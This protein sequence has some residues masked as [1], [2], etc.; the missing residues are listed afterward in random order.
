MKSRVEV[1]SL[2]AKPADI[3]S[4]IQPTNIYHKKKM[5]KV[6]RKPHHL[7][8]NPP[9]IDNILAGLG[10]SR[11]NRLPSIDIKKGIF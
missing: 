5:T 6:M 8:V 3:Y 9:V 4:S 7:V 2:L 1:K 10:V 11:S